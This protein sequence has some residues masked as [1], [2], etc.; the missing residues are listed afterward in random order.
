MD[1]TVER[2]HNIDNATFLREYSDRNRPVIISGAIDHW[3]AR[4]TWSLDYF[5]EHFGEKELSFSNKCWKIAE[6]VDLLRS[7]VQPAPYL[8]QVKLDEQF[9]ELYADIGDLAYTRDNLLDNRFLPN[10]MRIPRGIKALFIGGAGSGFGKL[11]WD[12]SCLHVFISQVKG[13]KDF[14]IFSPED[15]PYLYPNPKYEGESLIKDINNFDLNDWPNFKKATPIRFT[16]KEGETA[17]IPGCWWHSTKMHGPSIS[18]AESALN[19]S[20]WK[21]RQ[22][23][24]LESYR[25][26]NVPLR[27]RLLLDIYMRGLGLIAA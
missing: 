17:F 19:R 7:G 24:F 18:L 4:K 27:K 25:A 10:S 12:Y 11:H 23:W 2:V 22:D 15:T 14:M 5:A 9:T 16:V 20:N 1:I 6:F 13:D 3:P 26:N 8:N 21:L